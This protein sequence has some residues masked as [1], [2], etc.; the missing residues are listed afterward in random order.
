VLLAAGGV[1]YGLA[2][3][4]HSRLQ[5]RDASLAT[6]GDARRSASQGRTFQTLG[7]GLM[8]AGLVGLGVATGLYASSEPTGQISIDAGTSGTSAFIHGSWP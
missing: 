4:E 6:L 3:K 8:G 5:N 2:R 7:F 1:F